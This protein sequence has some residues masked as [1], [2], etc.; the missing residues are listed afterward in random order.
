MYFGTA[1]L[2]NI[3]RAH[4]CWTSSR[5]NL[6][7]TLSTLIDTKGRLPPQDFALFPDFLSLREQR[8]LLFAALQQ[9]DSAESRQFRRQRKALA[10]SRPSHTGCSL[11][12]KNLFLPDEY[13]QF[14]QVRLVPITLREYTLITVPRGTMTK[15]SR[16]IARCMSLPGW[17]TILH[18]RPY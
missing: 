13:Y 11:A 9:L 6:R 14:E 5:N 3:P 17:T 16:T 2:S 7:R 18:L 1:I 10:A 15:S 4:S 8:V 12:V